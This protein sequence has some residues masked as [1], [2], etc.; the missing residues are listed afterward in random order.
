VNTT[1][2]AVTA[3]WVNDNGSVV[4][5]TY[6]GYVDSGFVLAGNKSAFEATWEDSVEW[7]VRCDPCVRGVGLELTFVQTFKFTTS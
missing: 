2:G 5:P 3:A 7:V 6:I 1:S 4:L